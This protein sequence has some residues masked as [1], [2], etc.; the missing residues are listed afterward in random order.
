ME[1]AREPTST[2]Q[3]L[4]LLQVVRFIIMKEIIW[5][6]TTNPMKNF[7]TTNA[8]FPKL[9]M[10]LHNYTSQSILQNFLVRSESEHFKTGALT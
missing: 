6:G 3:R 8:M 4:H 7:H 5:C 10:K 1:K 9:L 2:L